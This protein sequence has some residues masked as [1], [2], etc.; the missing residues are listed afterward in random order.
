MISNWEVVEVR[1]I[2]IATPAKDFVNILSISNT[3]FLYIGKF[4]NVPIWI[5]PLLMNGR[6]R[7]NSMNGITIYIRFKRKLMEGTDRKTKENIHKSIVKNTIRH[8][9]DKVF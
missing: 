4:M 8:A 9:I 1:D 2:A 7:A 5:S 3:P 6:R